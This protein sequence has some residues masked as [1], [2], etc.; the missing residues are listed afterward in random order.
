M[1]KK[2][3]GGREYYYA[4]YRDSEGK[5]RTKYLGVDQNEAIKQEKEFLKKPSKPKT[6]IDKKT[7][8]V[9]TLLIGVFAFV[10]FASQGN[11]VGFLFLDTENI[12]LFDIQ[13]EW[14]LTNANIEINQNE[15]TYDIENVTSLVVDSQIWVY[16]EEYNLTEGY[17]NVSLIINATVVANEYVYYTPPSTE[18]EENITEENITETNVTEENITEEV[19]S[20][21]SAPGFFIADSAQMQ[22]ES[23]T[24]SPDFLYQDSNL[25]CLNGST[26]TDVT[27]LLYLWYVNQT[28]IPNANYSTLDQGNFTVHN[29]IEC[30]ILPRNITSPIAYYPIDAGKGDTAYE[31]VSGR[32]GSITSSDWVKG[33]NFYGLNST[34]TNNFPSSNITISDVTNLNLTEVFTYEVW[35]KRQNDALAT[36]IIYNLGNFSLGLTS[37]R[38]AAFFLEEGDTTAKVKINSTLSVPLDSWYHLAFVYNGSDL[39]L[40]VNGTLDNRTNLKGG[41]IDNF[42]ATNAYIGAHYSTSFQGFLGIID[43]F[44]LYNQSLNG[45][46]IKE[47][48]DKG[49]VRLSRKSKQIIDTVQSNFQNGTCIQTNC[50]R[51]SG[52]VTLA[53]S[54]GTTFYPKGNFTSKAYQFLNGPQPA[55]LFFNN[56]TSPGTNLSFQVRTGRLVNGSINFSDFSGPDPT[57]LV[58]D[59]IILALSFS[60]NKGN[61]SYNPYGTSSKMADNDFSVNGKHGSAAFLNNLE[62]I[63]VDSYEAITLSEYTNFSVEFWVYPYD[64]SQG[65]LLSKGAKYQ[66]NFNTAGNIVFNGVFESIAG[67]LTGTSTVPQFEWTHV[68]LTND[69]DN[70]TRLYVNGIEENSA[71]TLGYMT[72]GSGDLKIGDGVTS[73]P[74]WGKIDSLVMYERT[75]SAQ[76][77][78]Q[79]AQDKFTENGQYIGDINRYVQYKAFFETD[80]TANSPT[81]LD[82]T[83][84]AENYTNFVNNYQPTNISLSAPTN[85]SNLTENTPFNWT[86]SSDTESNTLF[87]EFVLTNDTS[88]S[89]P[90]VAR[91]A[92]NNF[93]KPSIKDD[94]YTT[95]ILDFE[96]KER[97]I[98]TGWTFVENGALT[99]GRFGNGWLFDGGSMALKTS[100]SFLNKK[101][102]SVEMWIKPDW[103]QGDSGQINTFLNIE[104]LSIIARRNSTDMWFLFNQ[105]ALTYNISNWNRNENHHLA[106]TWDKDANISLILDGEK[107]NTTLYPGLTVGSGDAYIGTNPSAIKHA[108]ATID[109][110]RFSNVPRFTTN[111]LNVTNFIL[112]K[113]GISDGPYYWKSRAGNYYNQKYDNETI[114]SNWSSTQTVIF[115]AQTP[116][117]NPTGSIY[118][119]FSE[120]NATINISTS[121]P[122]TCTYRNKTSTLTSMQTTGNVNHATRVNLTEYGP[123]TWYVSCTDQ[124]GNNVNSSFTYYVFSQSSSRTT[125]ST[126]LNL[127]A[128]ETKG[129]NFTDSDGDII[130]AINITTT[131]DV[132]GRVALVRHSP[133]NQPEKNLNNIE[134]RDYIY[135]HTFIVDE[136]IFENLS[137]NSTVN[138]VFETSS[139]ANADAETLNLN[140]YNL[141]TEEWNYVPTQEAIPTTSSTF[142]L[143]T[144]QFGTYVISGYNIDESP[145][146]DDSIEG[147]EGS[148]D[149]DETEEIEITEALDF[150]FESIFEGEETFLGIYDE[151][152]GLLEVIFAPNKDLSVVSMRYVGI[153]PELDN[154]YGAFSLTGTGIDDSDLEYLVGSFGLSKSWVDSYSE[155]TPLIV[156]HEDGTEYEL[157]YTDEDSDFYYFEADLNRLGIFTVI[158][159]TEEDFAELAPI[160]EEQN[161]VQEI[162]TE[163]GEILT[164]KRGLPIIG[165][166]LVSSFLVFYLSRVGIAIYYTRKKKYNLSDEDL[167]VKPFDISQIVHF[168]YENSAQDNLHEELMNRGV[169]LKRAKQVVSRVKNVQKNPLTNYIFSQLAKG[170]DEQSIKQ[171]LADK[172][173]Q[174]N[175]IQRKIEEFKKI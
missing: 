40:Y 117:I 78:Y 64:N 109:E 140:H 131:N 82:V 155:E 74:V 108:N 61:R 31:L 68:A 56:V 52:N 35:I 69:R 120:G 12:V 103:I 149:D 105:T 2:K 134:T 129:F 26:S 158:A 141:E 71:T 50:T 88:H 122:A 110:V 119:I 142:P 34:G 156:V 65:V 54:S 138:L 132:E 89:S 146:L 160:V 67:T 102:G 159:L 45:T 5:V 1:H 60:E 42:T 114:Y 62:P 145:L 169:D 27:E 172:G 79:R 85:N 32:D 59:K 39:F 6:K 14:N 13:E 90:V 73:N 162:F 135:F 87:Y 121:E 10:F 125:S 104:P 44:I 150:F 175:V 55:K 81:L 127:T 29:E 24:I 128:G 148:L 161:V 23:A 33:R 51:E 116:R 46:V 95:Y 70:I 58:D 57:K 168:A 84:Q 30:G 126:Y 53:Y 75:L 86:E 123:A 8:L 144:K 41:K 171:K 100:N 97:M 99:Q 153:E 83:L 113:S 112:N 15:T 36:Q 170:L 136:H 25:A 47:H 66:M 152:S 94:N 37:D 77:I 92:V 20:I 91:M 48:Y 101:R 98:L 18:S 22:V 43:E 137:I 63:T 167:L 4:S 111:E 49:I 96:S 147:G 157:Y 107:V 106:I 151:S 115:D 174:E 3:I 28:Y 17:W 130:G 118:K 38:A 165:Y 76:E 72:S 16:L 9:L 154:A 21:A 11:L 124:S 143:N 19:V 164:T 80:D 139:L 93:S 166:I 163:I 7:Y 133:S 173:W